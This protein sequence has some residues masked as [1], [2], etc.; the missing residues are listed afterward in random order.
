MLG[1]R[2]S[3]WF[4]GRERLE[5]LAIRIAMQG[6]SRALALARFL[7]AVERLEAM[8]VYSAAWFVGECGG[9]VAED[10]AEAWAIIA[11]FG[12]HSMEQEFVPLAA[13]YTALRDMAARRHSDRLRQGRV[14]GDAE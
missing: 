2:D 10:E 1:T 9:E 4:Q 6:G 3:W 14:A 5:S 7:T 11:R 12:E 8:D 13:R